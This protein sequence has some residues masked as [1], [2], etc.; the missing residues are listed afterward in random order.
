MSEGERQRWRP[1]GDVNLR[2]AMRD[3]SIGIARDNE[4]KLLQ[5][6]E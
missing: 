4:G 3:T 1:D 5:A 6:I 2:L